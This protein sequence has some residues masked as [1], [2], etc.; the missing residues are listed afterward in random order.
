MDTKLKYRIS[1]IDPIKL[2]QMEE[3]PLDSEGERKA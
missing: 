1:L 2:R 3:F